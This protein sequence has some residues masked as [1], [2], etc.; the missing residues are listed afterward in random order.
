[1]IRDSGHPV[2][3]QLYNV[4]VYTWCVKNHTTKIFAVFSDI[5]WNFIAKLYRSI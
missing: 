1:M 2:H 3:I 4:P 5:D